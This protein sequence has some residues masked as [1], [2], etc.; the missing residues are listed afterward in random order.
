MAYNDIRS[1][2]G[3]INIAAQ[4]VVSTASAAVAQTTTTAYFPVA[5]STFLVSLAGCASG[6][7]SSN[8]VSNASLFALVYTTSGT[9]TATATSAA[10]NFTAANQA[11]APVP[12]QVSTNIPSIAAP[13][14]AVIAIITK[15]TGTAS[16]TETVS[17]LNVIIGVAPQYV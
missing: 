12:S 3:P 17:A 2:I 4:N 6:A 15:G 7:A 14:G 16:A 5:E 8:L 1:Y 9:T 10:L 13:A 11:A